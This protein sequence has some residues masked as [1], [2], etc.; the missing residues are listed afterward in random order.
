MRV[1]RHTDEVPASVSVVSAADLE[2]KNRKNLYDALRDLEGL[3]FGYSGSVAQQVAPTLRGVGGSYAGSTT[4]VLVDGMG[5]D[6]AVS[7]LLGHGGLNFTSMQDIERVE[8]V[9]GPA[10][11]VYGPGVIGGV[12]IKSGAKILSG[13]GDLY[14]TGEST[15]STLIYGVGFEANSGTKTIVGSEKADHPTD[16]QVVAMARRYFHKFDNMAGNAGGR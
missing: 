4:Q 3:D 15:A 1:A 6:A 7:N 2:T 12:Y 9:R 13:T 5:H 16:G 10:S 11:A 8:V 14:I